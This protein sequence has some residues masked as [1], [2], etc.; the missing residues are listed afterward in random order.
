[1]RCLWF[2]N[3]LDVLGKR[4]TIN[5]NKINGG[6]G[7]HLCS[8]EIDTGIVT[9]VP[10]SNAFIYTKITKAYIYNVEHVQS[11]YSLKLA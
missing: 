6:F 9:I 11:M 8:Y 3:K 10:P 1:M 5:Q 7:R 2:G 4:S